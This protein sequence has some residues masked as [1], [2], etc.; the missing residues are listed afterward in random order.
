MHDGK[1]AADGLDT[2]D[3]VNDDDDGLM[4]VMSSAVRYIHIYTIK[5]G[6]TGVLEDVH[7]RSIVSH[8]RNDNAV[9]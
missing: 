9:F 4:R 5:K 3:D 7:R 1:Y 2:V 8:A 6:S